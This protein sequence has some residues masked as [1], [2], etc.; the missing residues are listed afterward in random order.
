M[1][2]L[3]IKWTKALAKHF[4]VRRTTFLADVWPDENATEDDVAC[5]DLA[6]NPPQPSTTVPQLREIIDSN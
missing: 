2:T 1:P 6:R 4:M 3:A 5:K